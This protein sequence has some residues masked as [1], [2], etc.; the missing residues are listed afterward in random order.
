MQEIANR[1]DDSL[2]LLTAGNRTAVPRQRTLRG[3]LDWSHDLLSWPE[4]ALFRRLSAFAGGWTLKAAEAVGSGDGL[5]EHEVLNLLSGLVDKSLV[6]AV[7]TEEGSVRYRLLKCVRQYAREKLRE[8]SEMRPV[9]LRHAV[10]CLDLAQNAQ[11]GLQGPEQAS[12][13]GG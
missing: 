6:L 1:L 10:W 2:M 13:I 8:S 3:A 5:E 7:A 12:W 9:Q 11:R 4:R